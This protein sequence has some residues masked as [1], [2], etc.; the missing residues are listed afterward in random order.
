ML[1]STKLISMFNFI[2][3]AHFNNPLWDFQVCSY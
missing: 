2:N 1:V 3:K